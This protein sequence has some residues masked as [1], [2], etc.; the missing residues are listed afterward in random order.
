[1]TDS[2]LASVPPNPIFSDFS[3][4][5]VLIV[6]DEP[7]NREIAQT[8]LSFSDVKS[9]TAVD[10]ADGLKRLESLFP[11]FVLLDLSMPVMDGWEMFKEMRANPI[12]AHIPVIALT[13]HAMA[14]DRDRVFQA[15]FDGYIAKPFR[16][17]TFMNELIQCLNKF[18]AKAKM[19]V[20]K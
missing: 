16:I 1:M 11:T 7:D 20:T 13:A 8:V 4:W 2:Q 19:Q 17:G 6:D 12:T 3:H 15:G 5:T 9:Y 10:G 14:G 18:N